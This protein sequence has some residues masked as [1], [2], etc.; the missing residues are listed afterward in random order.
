MVEINKARLASSEGGQ[1]RDGA[2]SF[3]GHG[4]DAAQ[5]KPLDPTAVISA[6][7]ASGRSWATKDPRLSLTAAE[8]LKHLTSDRTRPPPVC[9][10]VQTAPPLT[11]PPSPRPPHLALPPHHGSNHHGSHHHGVQPRRPATASRWWARCCPEEAARRQPRGGSP[12]RK[13]QAPPTSSPEE[14]PRSP[15]VQTRAR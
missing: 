9:L 12:V 15:P 2:P 3:V 14:A 7:D 11:S 6:L 1:P 13:R 10:L 5:G 8:W 4:F